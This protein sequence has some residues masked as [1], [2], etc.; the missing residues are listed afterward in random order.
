MKA[1]QLN[2]DVEAGATFR[3]PLELS[4]SDETP[5]DLTGVT[6]RSHW[7]TSIDDPTVLLEL[8]TENGR[9]VISGGV[10]TIVLFASETTAFTFTSAVYDLE[11]VF[12]QA[13]EPDVVR[14]LKGKVKISREITR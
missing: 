6:A 1:A 14:L 3:Y 4:N 11:L 2:L 9:L 8:T 7:R 12:P 13:G 5:V 10:L